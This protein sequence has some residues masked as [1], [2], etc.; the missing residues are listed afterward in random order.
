VI[1]LHC[2]IT[3]TYLLAIYFGF[4]QPSSGIW[5]NLVAVEVNRK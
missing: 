5:Y 2:H 1:V 4:T 3:L